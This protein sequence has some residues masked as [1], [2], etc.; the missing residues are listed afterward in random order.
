M[1]RPVEITPVGL[2]KILFLIVLAI[3]LVIFIYEII[4][5]TKL[6]KLFKSEKRYDNIG[7]RIGRLCKF[8]FGQRRLLDQLVM[9]SAHF[10]IFWGFVIISFATLN[11]FGKGIWSG[12]EL[13]ILGSSLHKP[14]LFLVDLFSLLVLVGII[15][16]LIKRYIIRAKRMS[17]GLEPLIILVLIGGLMVF[18]LLSDAFN[19]AAQGS[20]EPAAFAGT[21]LAKFFLTWSFPPGSLPVWAHIFWWMHMLFFLTMLNYVPVS[22]HM[23]VFSSLPNVF[24]SSLK[25]NGR[26]SKLNLEDEEAEEFGVTQVEQYTWK[27]L[28]DGYSC[29]ECGRCQDQCPAYNTD[30]PLSPKKII[31]QLREHAEKKGSA[32]FKGKGEEFTERFIEDV[33]TEDVIWD[34]TTCYACMRACP[35][36]IEHIPKLVDL[37]RS[38]VL[39]EGRI[40]SE[41]A[42]ALKNIEKA[43]DPWGLGQSARAEWYKGLDVK[44]ISD[45]PDAEYLFWVGCAGALDDR[46]IKVSRAT[47]ELMNKAG[48]SYA[49]LGTDETCNGDPARR[50]GE[51]YLYQTMA[52]AIPPAG[53]GRS[54][55]IRPWRRPTWRCS[56]RPVSR[57]YSPTARTVSTP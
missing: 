42:L 57:R 15:I 53:W 28:L 2:E 25:P 44:H 6:L 16:A 7:A 33:I 54:T 10:M 19:M 41:G 31:M 46:N 50:L 30:K 21:Y 12:F 17:M 34:C 11:F 1:F 20:F 55:S 26:L 22:K 38:L 56:T 45:R 40:S 51:E 36:F 32:I 23:H 37:R 8:V 39:N 13:P 3:G 27:D 47:V 35:L 43:G 48:V 5:Y 14:F 24:F 52:Q 18:D 49:I 9:G 4:F 29:T